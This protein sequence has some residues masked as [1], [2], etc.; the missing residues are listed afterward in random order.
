MSRNGLHILLF[1][2]ICRHHQ[3]S[4]ADLKECCQTGELLLSRKVRRWLEA[5]RLMASYQL[6]TFSEKIVGCAG[7]VK[8]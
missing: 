8:F 7:Q 3:L 2:T 4:K 1:Q 6:A 5:L